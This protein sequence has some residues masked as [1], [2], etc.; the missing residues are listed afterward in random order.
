M[1]LPVNHDVTFVTAYGVFTT[2]RYS[3]RSYSLFSVPMTTFHSLRLERIVVML[4]N[5]REYILKDVEKEA[6]LLVS[7]LTGALE[8]HHSNTVD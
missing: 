6:A 5:I 2:P 8:L 4:V 1:T 7:K 3:L